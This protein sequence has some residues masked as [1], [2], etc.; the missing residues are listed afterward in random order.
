MCT[1]YKC[2]SIEISLT[3]AYHSQGN[4]KV[5]CK[6]QNAKQYL[7][8]FTGKCQRNWSGHLLAA[9]F[10]LN[11]HQHAGTLKLPLEI[12]YRCLPDFFISIRK[13]SNIPDLET[14]LDNLAKACQEAKVALCL[15]KKCMKEQYEHNKKTTYSFK[16]SNLVWLAFKDIKIY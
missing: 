8:I 1:L 10:T 15:S 9:K 11:S 16:V 5:K 2:L 4:G 6:N 3:T 12:I 13:C 7:Q 14:H